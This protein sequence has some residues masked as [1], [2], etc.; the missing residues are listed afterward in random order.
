MSVHDFNGPKNPRSPAGTID[1]GGEPPD[2]GRMEKRVE[3]LESDLTAMKVDL[4]VIKSNYATN[5]DIAKLGLSM[6]S[7]I[8]AQTWKLIIWVCSFGTALV[9]A[10]YFIA[11][12]V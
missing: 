3:K 4:A 5:T 2:D 8:N 7:E 9:A 6:Q 12:H 1:N 10:T 11:K